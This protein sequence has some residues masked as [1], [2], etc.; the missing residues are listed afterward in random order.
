MLFSLLAN[1]SVSAQENMSKNWDI[2]KIRGTR[3]LPYPSATGRPYLND[4]FAN[5]EI[6]F[7][8]G[9][10]VENIGLR[11]SCYR[12]QIIY[13]NKSISTQIEID[14]A[15]LKGFSFADDNGLKR[16]FRRL[17]YEGFQ[18]NDRFF[19]VL[20]DGEISLLAY[21]KVAL[22]IC[23]T[24]TDADGKVRNMEYQDDFTYYFYSKDKGFT[25]VKPTKSS[26]LS[27]FDKTTQKA[28]KRLL[29]KN[30]VQISDE[31]GFIKAWNVIKENGIKVNF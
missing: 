24:Y 2:E 21:R 29:R 15:S 7:S 17:H 13:Y 28:V 14:K 16:V 25:P 6:E 1:T 12:D 20:S 9:L 19:E 27:K 22:Q 10:K 4:K 11:Y 18:S 26:L 5:G 8:N 30:G 23:A 3:H 31:S